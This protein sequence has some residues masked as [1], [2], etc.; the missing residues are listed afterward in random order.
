MLTDQLVVD[1]GDEDLPYSSDF[2]P[3]EHMNTL[4]DYSSHPNVLG[5]SI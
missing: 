2:F 3:G 5:G 1:D 4:V